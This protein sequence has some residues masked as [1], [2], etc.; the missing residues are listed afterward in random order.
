MSQDHQTYNICHNIKIISY[1]IKKNYETQ[2]ETKLNIE[3]WG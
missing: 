3:G 1:K 2:F